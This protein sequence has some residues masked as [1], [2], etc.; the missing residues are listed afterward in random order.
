[1]AFMICLAALS[2]GLTQKSFSDLAWEVATKPGSMQVMMSWG[3]FLRA[4]MDSPSK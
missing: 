3:L 4:R 1:M 2:T